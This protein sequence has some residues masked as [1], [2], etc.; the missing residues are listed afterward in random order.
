MMTNGNPE[1]WIFYP[2]L[3]QIVDYFS[4]T[5]FFFNFKINF[6]KSLNTQF[7]MMTSLNITM[8]SLDDHVVSSY[9]TNVCSSH[10]TAWV[11]IAWVR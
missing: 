4:C 10:V 8:T 9:T 6:K 1:G 5:L 7:D 2:T 3:T 11:K